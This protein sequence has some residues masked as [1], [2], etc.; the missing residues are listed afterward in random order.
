MVYYWQRESVVVNTWFPDIIGGPGDNPN[1]KVQLGI[2]P[3][4]LLYVLLEV[5]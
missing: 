5:A 1:K 4:I 2:A 3:A